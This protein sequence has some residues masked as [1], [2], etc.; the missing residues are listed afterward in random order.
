MENFLGLARTHPALSWQ[1]KIFFFAPSKNDE[2][3][4]KR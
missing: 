1:R 4:N 3:V 2:Q